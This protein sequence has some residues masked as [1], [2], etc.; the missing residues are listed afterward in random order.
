[1][2]P[3]HLREAAA[4]T[5]SSKVPHTP[6][7]ECPACVEGYPRPCPRVTGQG[8]HDVGYDAAGQSL[9]STWGPT[10]CE[11]FVHAEMAETLE[12]RCSACGMPP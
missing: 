1:M 10:Y 4:S 6:T 12:T 2:Q 9:G 11:G 3:F 7:A 5:E 8:F